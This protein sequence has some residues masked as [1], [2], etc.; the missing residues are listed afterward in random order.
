MICEALLLSDKLTWKLSEFWCQT[1]ALIRRII[2]GVDYKVTVLCYIC[3]IFVYEKTKKQ[4]K[5]EMKIKQEK[6]AAQNKIIL[7]MQDFI[8][9]LISS[10]VI[11]KGCRDLLRQMLEKT[12]SIPVTEN[13]CTLRCVD[14][15]IEVSI[16]CIL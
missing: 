14:A 4:K 2:G 16:V 13:V 3:H 15:V 12:Q 10:V 9:I 8:S 7:F 1:F 6:P 5:T 11:L